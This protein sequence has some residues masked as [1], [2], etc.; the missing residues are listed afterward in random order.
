S[1]YLY[2]PM[3]CYPAADPGG[4]I[5]DASEVTIHTIGSNNRSL[6]LEGL[7]AGYVLTAGD[8]LAFDYGASPVRRAWHRLAETVTASGSGLTPLFD[9]ST[10]LRPGATTGLAVTLKKPAAK[11]FRMPG[12]LSVTHTHTDAII[13]FQAAQRP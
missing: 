9:L 13:S 11:M 1:F 5:L 2:S 7:P 12:P 6:R 10:H 3:N 4:V 8:A